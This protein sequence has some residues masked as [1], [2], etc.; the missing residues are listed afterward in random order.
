MEPARILIVDDEPFNLDLL[1]QELELLGHTSIRAANGL[2]AL[3]RLNE[4]P[5]DLVLLDVMMPALDGYAVLERMKA[6]DAWRHT[7]VVMISALVE[8]GSI[9]RCIELGAEDYLPKPF[10]PV[11]LEARIRS[12]LERKRFHDREMAH[13]RTIE[14]ERSR[15][16]EL[17]H[18][19][20]PVSA[21]AELME[22]GQVKP[23]LFD[24]VAV[25][26]IDLV[27]FTAWC[28]RQTPD[29]VVAEIHRLAE[30]FEI[31][32]QA[33]GLENIKTIGDAFMATANLLR[34]HAD[35]VE[36]AIRCASDM[37]GVAAAGA[38]GWRIRAGIH[39]G[40]VVGGIVGRTKY[41][42]DLWGDTV[43]VAAR[44]SG[45]GDGCTLHLSREAFARLAEPRSVKPIGQVAL[46]GKGEIDVYCYPLAGQVV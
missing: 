7:P 10:E 21:V 13:L 24:D 37:V 3:D 6:H 40:S 39:I 26:F 28:H 5:F 41:T 1:E 22:T 15:A 42:F 38:P 20:L 23:R 11:L 35:P 2:A 16:D 12:C 4:T 46:R 17:L 30:A 8:I 25:L 18:A 19:I 33:H 43:N 36:A 9:V 44:L 14:R 27:G 29:T 34:P 45:L 31:A 32:A